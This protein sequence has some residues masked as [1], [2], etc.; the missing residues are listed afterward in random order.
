MIFINK[1]VCENILEIYRLKFNISYSIFRIGV[2]YGNE[3]GFEASYG[4]VGF[5]MSS[6]KKGHNIKVYGSGDM[7]RTFTYVMDVCKQ[8]YFVSLISDNEVLNI[9]GE[10]LSI[11]EVG[12]LV[13]RKHEL[14]IEFCP[15]S[16]RDLILESGDTIFNCSKI[17]K[18]LGDF[19]IV[20]FDNWINTNV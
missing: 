17:R 15:F 1:F 10:N 20:K 6:A 7:R 9:I 11:L 2:P 19:E 18:F 5:F 12:V 3:L 14:E 13:A 4:T 8:V 16:E